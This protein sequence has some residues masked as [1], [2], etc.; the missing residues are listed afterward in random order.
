MAAP[1]WRLPPMGEEMGDNLKKDNTAK[2]KREDKRKQ[3]GI[4]KHNTSCYNVFGRF[5]RA[6]A[7]RDQ[8]AAG[9]S[10]ATS[11]K[12]LAL[13]HGVFPDGTRFFLIT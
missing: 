4:E 5:F 3:A 10:P 8:K 12:L 13:Y 7:L 1:C 11:T 6:G 9:S 2:R